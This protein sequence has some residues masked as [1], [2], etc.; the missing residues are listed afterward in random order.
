MRLLE[1]DLEALRRQEESGLIGDA[2]LGQERELIPVAPLAC[3]LAFPYLG[4]QRPRHPHSSPD[5]GDGLSREGSKPFGVGT[6]PTPENA[7]VI[8]FGE[9]VQHLEVDVGEGSH[10]ALLVPYTPWFVQGD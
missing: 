5:R 10:E 2:Q 8:A 6:A 3:D 7:D 1:F 9:D 4:E